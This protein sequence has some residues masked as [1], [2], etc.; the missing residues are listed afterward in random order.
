MNPLTTDL[1]RS[2]HPEVTDYAAL[3]HQT[4]II[5]GLVRSVA[6]SSVYRWLVFLRQVLFSG[7]PAV[8]M[9]R[10]TALDRGHLRL[11]GDGQAK[12]PITHCTDMQCLDVSKHADALD[13]LHGSVHRD[14]WTECS[15]QCGGQ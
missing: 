4:D 8:R 9:N 11:I 10:C 14:G 15:I 1:A 3:V 12:L 5:P 6:L 7:Y 2:L 13:G